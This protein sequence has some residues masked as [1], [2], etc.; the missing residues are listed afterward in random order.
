MNNEGKEPNRWLIIFGFQIYFGIV[1][2]I[3]WRVLSNA[4][5]VSFPI[6][7]SFSVLF[8]SLTA[9]FLFL[10]GTISFWSKEKWTFSYFAKIALFLTILAFLLAKYIL[11]EQ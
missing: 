3:L 4:F 1:H 9:Y 5:S 2:S 11:N 10:H 6:A 8:T 7:F